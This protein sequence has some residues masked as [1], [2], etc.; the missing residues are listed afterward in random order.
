MNYLSTKNRWLTVCV[1]LGSTV[2]SYNA[3]ALTG[4]KSFGGPGAIHSIHSLQQLN[5]SGF[6]TNIGKTSLGSRFLSSPGGK[7]FITQGLQAQ[8]VINNVLNNNGGKT[9]AY[10]GNSGMTWFNGPAQVG[11]Q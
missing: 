4:V 7:I 11:Y 1:L 6:V 10:T 2:F 8:T 3:N 9:G 5:F